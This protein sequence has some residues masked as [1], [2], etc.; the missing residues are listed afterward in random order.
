VRCKDASKFITR[1]ILDRE[2]PVSCVCGVHDLETSQ[3]A[4]RLVLALSWKRVVEAAPISGGLEGTE[5]A[6]TWVEQATTLLF[7]PGEPGML[8]CIAG[9]DTSRRIV[10]AQGAVAITASASISAESGLEMTA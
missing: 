10:V 9:S 4:G 3:S 5:H 6:A 7:C 2:A 8:L 1:R